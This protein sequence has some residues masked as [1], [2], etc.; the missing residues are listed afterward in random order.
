MTLSALI[1]VAY[2][3]LI[4]ENF[5]NHKFGLIMISW[6]LVLASIWLCTFKLILP[7]LNG[8]MATIV[9]QPIS[10]ISKMMFGALMALACFTVNTRV[11]TDK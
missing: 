7:I 5:C 6:L 2:G 3:K 9:P 8:D 10:F 4:V 11:Q 1:G